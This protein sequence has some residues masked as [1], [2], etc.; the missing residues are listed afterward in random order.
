MNDLF[1]S[2]ALGSFAGA[3]AAPQTLEP[4]TSFA[5]TYYSEPG[6]ILYLLFTWA[7]PT[8]GPTPDQYS[9]EFNSTNVGTITFVGEAFTQT[10]QGAYNDYFTATVQSL[11][12][13]YEPSDLAYLSGTTPEPPYP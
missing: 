6:P 4:P 10:I 11:K 12:S 2:L 5:Y 9:F 1:I 8:F 7:A 13:G 3:E